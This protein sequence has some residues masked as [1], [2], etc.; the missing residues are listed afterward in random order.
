MP[1]DIPTD[2][3]ATNKR[4]WE[5]RVDEFVKRHNLLTANL[6]TAFSL[7]LRHC[8]EF[9]RANLD[10][11]KDW[12][13]LQDSFDLIRLINA[14]KGLPYQLYCQ[15]YHTLALHQSKK[16]FFGLYQ[17]RDTNNDHYLDNFMTRVSVVEQYGS[18][19][20]KDYGAI[21]D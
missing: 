1:A 13:G 18:C 15:K 17:G 9:M 10:A 20:G 16:S 21:Q 3:S 19:I 12:K 8:T 5:H 7:V 6:K 4:V 2:A 14:I 11:L